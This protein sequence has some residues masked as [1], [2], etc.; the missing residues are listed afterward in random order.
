MEPGTGFEPAYKNRF[1]V[2]RV[3][4]PPPGRFWGV[5]T[6]LNCHL[7]GSQP[8]ALPLCYLRHCLAE[9]VRFELTRPD[10]GLT[11]FKTATVTQTLSVYSSCVWPRRRDSNP[12]SVSTRLISNQVQSARLCHSSLAS[13]LFFTGHRRTSREHLTASYLTR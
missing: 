4:I 8:R 2:C 13:A 10:K 11:V 12:R 3:A 6:D 7:L 5:G 9:E 1:A